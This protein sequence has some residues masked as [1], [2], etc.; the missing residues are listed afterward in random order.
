MFNKYILYFLLFWSVT[1]LGYSQQ[2]ASLELQSTVSFKADSLLA[3]DSYGFYY[4]SKD[5]SVIKTNFDK[6]FNYQNT[7]LGSPDYLDV[8]NPLQ[9]VLFYKKFNT[10]VLLDNQL[11]ETSIINGNQHKIVFETVGLARQNKLWF[12][13]SVS[14]KF[15]LFN[16]K[17]NKISFIS[18]FYPT[19]FTTT[20][21]NY[22]YFYWMDAANILHSISF[23]G[24]IS[25][26]KIVPQLNGISFSSEREYVVKANDS[27]VYY[28]NDT[29][30]N[31]NLLVNSSSNFCFKDGI[32]AIFTNNSVTNYK[33]NLP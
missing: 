19:S 10:V 16:S 20:F 6:K 1:F 21:S 17:E 11:N 14:Q 26:I 4:F 18:T 5:N 13:D 27:F 12:Y 3:I 2:K 15:G 25:E 30:Y 23:Y 22:N 24:K 33:I 8:T 29:A 32:L 7:A 28:K 31:L 9:L